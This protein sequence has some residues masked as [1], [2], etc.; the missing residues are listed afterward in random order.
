MAEKKPF[1]NVMEYITFAR[2]VAQMDLPTKEEFGRIMHDPNIDEEKKKA[3]ALK[4]KE[5]ANGYEN[6]Q[7]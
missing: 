5:V 1:T 4:V 6:L 3:I 2:K 7:D